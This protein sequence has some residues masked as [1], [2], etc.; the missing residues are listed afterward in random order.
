MNF[1]KEYN[2]RELF[3]QRN[4]ATEGCVKF[5]NLLLSIKGD[6]KETRK[7]ILKLKNESLVVRGKSFEANDSV[8]AGLSSIDNKIEK[9]ILDIQREIP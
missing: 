4:D 5:G 7:L 6:L 8:E 3:K 1:D 2:I 9:M